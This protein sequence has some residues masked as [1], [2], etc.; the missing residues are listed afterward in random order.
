MNITLSAN[1]ELIEKAREYAKQHNSS[2]NRL[3]REYLTQLVDRMDGESAA[4]EFE[5]LCEKFAGR[6]PAGYRF[7]REQTYDRGQG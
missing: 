7:V 3:I 6:S 1:K 2:L 4:T 5:Q